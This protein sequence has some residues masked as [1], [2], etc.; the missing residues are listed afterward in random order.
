MAAQE[1]QETSRNGNGLDLSSRIEALLFVADEPVTVKQ[2]AQALEV[3]QRQVEA[4]LDQV[5]ADYSERGLRLQRQNDSIQFVTAPEAAASVERFL[6]LDLSSRL[7]TPALE[8]LALI[9]YRQP[10]TRAQIEAIRGVSSDGV[11]R[12]LLSRG[13]IAPLGRLA[14]V[15]RPIIYGTTLEFLQH[16]GLS[17]LDELPSIE[18]IQASMERGKQHAS[19]RTT[20][21][22]PANQEV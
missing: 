1:K 2:L 4:A 18:D 9:A 11:L 3:N 5:A 21:E 13:L 8:T 15:G 7:S 10:V 22:T 6:G 14:Q 19:G 20:D 12:T 17:D 16:F